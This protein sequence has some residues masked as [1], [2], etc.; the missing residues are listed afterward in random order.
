MAIGRNISVGIDVGTA[1]IKVIV[2]EQDL[3]SEKGSSSSAGSPSLSP[4]I[5]GSGIAESK[6]IRYGFVNNAVEAAKSIRAAVNMAEK[7]AGVPIRKAYVSVGGVGLSAII[8]VGGVAVTKADSEI[9]EL[10]IKRAVEESEKELP[11]SYIQNRKI[12]HTIPLEYR[13]DGKKVLGRPHGLKGLRL[14]ARVLYITCLT[15]HLNELMSAFEEADIEIKDVVASP[16]AASLITL[17]K[18]QKIA[19]CILANIGAETTSIMVF[20]NNI[21]VSME[22]FQIGSNDITNDIALGLKISIEEANEIKQG[23]GR[24]G[25]FSKRKLDEI[26]VARL[27]DIFDLI[28][29][30]LKKIDRNGLLPAGIIITGGGAGTVNIEDVARLALRLPSKKSSIKIES[31]NLG[32]LKNMSRD[33]EWSVAYG[34]VVLGLNNDHEGGGIGITG[35]TGGFKSLVFNTAWKKFWHWLKQFLP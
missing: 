21:P 26:V 29:D 12:I 31:S 2:A 19:G 13:I 23:F 15:H 25:E 1:Q 10:D 24:I 33:Y 6:G 11:N 16:I 28:E 14:E 17:S 4:K 18:T 8:A 3:K 27:S 34:L 7:S 30:H 35:L 20:E 22:V 5:I 32:V 9:T